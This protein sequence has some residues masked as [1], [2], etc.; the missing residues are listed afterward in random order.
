[1]AEGKLPWN[2]TICCQ[3][4][5]L[6][7]RQELCIAVVSRI[8]WIIFDAA[9]SLTNL[10]YFAFST[11]SSGFAASRGPAD[12]CL[13]HRWHH[14][15]VRCLKKQLCVLLVLKLFEQQVQTSTATAARCSLGKQELSC[16][17]LLGIQQKMKS[18][19]TIL[20]QR[21]YHSLPSSQ[22]E[23]RID[24][25]LVIYI[26]V[27]SAYCISITHQHCST[28][29]FFFFGSSYG[30]KCFSMDLLQPQQL[31]FYTMLWFSLYH[32]RYKT[33][34]LKYKPVRAIMKKKKKLVC[35]CFFSSILL[36]GCCLCG[37]IW[38]LSQE[39]CLLSVFPVLPGGNSK[40]NGCYH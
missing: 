11:S 23:K 34:I 40:E 20:G 3:W 14:W 32:H 22:L 38:P 13:C 31:F 2:I 12:V 33:H 10:C 25:I 37:L 4:S 6:N 9:G 35:V 7:Q 5:T 18:I 16:N 36:P 21:R 19:Y 8:Y 17:S 30:E 27:Q 39:R 1:M 26:L 28:V 15:K 29:F 24:N